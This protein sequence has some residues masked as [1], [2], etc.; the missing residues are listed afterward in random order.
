[1]ANRKKTDV[2]DY[3]ALRTALKMLSTKWAMF[4]GTM[5]VADMAYRN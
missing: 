3:L 1:M 4:L 2:N 5:Q